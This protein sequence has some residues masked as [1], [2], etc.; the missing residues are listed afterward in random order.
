M[1]NP[2]LHIR[3]RTMLEE[4]LEQVMLV[5]LAAY[6]YPWSHK[7]FLDCIS[8]GY[9]CLLLLADDVL[10]GY[11]VMSSGAG[12][13]HIQNLCVEPRHQGQGYGRRILEHLLNLAV[14]QQVDTVFLEVRA[15]NRAA[16]A[17]YDSMGF[18]EIGLRR[19]YY[20]LGK[21]RE[22][23]LIFALGLV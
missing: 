5:E 14:V 4:D 15:S 1:G 9:T 21:K 2:A 7:N 17:L 8:A 13:A 18:N 23:A 12:E 11:G 19:G 6:R 22:D 16:L 20:P 3:F 10:V